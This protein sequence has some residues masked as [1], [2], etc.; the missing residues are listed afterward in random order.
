[1]RML[2]VHL[3]AMLCV[4]AAAVSG[5]SENRGPHLPAPTPVPDPDP[6]PAPP[7]VREISIG[8][9]ISEDIDAAAK[10]CTTFRQW[11]VPC[12]YYAFT[13]T[14]NGTVTATL[15]WDERSTGCILLLRVDEKEFLASQPGWVPIVGQVP[16]VAG[17]RYTLDVGL[18]ETPFTRWLE[19]FRDRVPY[20]LEIAF[21]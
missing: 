20:T 4:M 17:R 21:K 1:M 3:A 10:P 9:T 6:A 19:D 7:S 16:V 13:P 18:A 2:F 8:D 14:A 11:P 12:Q 5:C 15:T